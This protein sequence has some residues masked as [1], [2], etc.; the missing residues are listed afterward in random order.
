LRNPSKFKFGF[1]SASRVK[2]KKPKTGTIKIFIKL[3]FLRKKPELEAQEKKCEQETNKAIP[4]HD[5]GSMNIQN[6]TN[7]A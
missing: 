2:A 7:L 4:I 1:N 6:W 5:R 3:F